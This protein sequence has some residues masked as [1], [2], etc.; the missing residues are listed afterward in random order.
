MTLPTF[1]EL[2]IETDG[3]VA[4]L[5]I[6]RPPANYFD[7]PLITA[8]ADALDALAE[9]GSARAA[10]LA[11]EGKHFCAGANF[12]AT[13]TGDDRVAESRRLYAEGARLFSSPIP[14]VAAVQGSAIGGGLG[15]ACATD[16]R[17]ASS[18]SRFWANFPRLGFHH[19][20]GLTESLPRIVGQ[21][22]ATRMLVGAERVQGERAFTLGLADRLAEPGMEREVAVAYARELASLAPLAVRSIRETLR[23]DLPERMAAAL[24]REAAEQAWLWATADGHEGITA[25]LERRDPVFTGR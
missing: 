25:S 1:D 20:F 14:V 18:T 11:S 15:L 10:V 7:R 23:G 4:V 22:A 21:Q 16:F 19:G 24:D 12:G 8:I 17:V 13:A 6:A 2:R 9:A 5:E 3:T